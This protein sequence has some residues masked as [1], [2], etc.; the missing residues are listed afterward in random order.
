MPPRPF[1][2]KLFPSCWPIIF[3]ICMKEAVLASDVI[4]ERGYR[5]LLGKVDLEKSGFLLLASSELPV[6]SFHSGLWMVTRQDSS[7]VRTI[8]GRAAATK[9]SSTRSPAGSSNP[10]R[11]PAALPEGVGRSQRLR[12]GLPKAPR[13]PMPWLL[14]GPALSQ[15]PGSGDSKARTSSA[16]LPS[17]PTGTISPSRDRT[18]YLAFDSDIV[19][20]EPVRK[21]LEHLGEHLKRKGATVHVIHLPQEGQRRRY[22]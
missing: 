15:S 9:R 20:K 10:S 8:P 21:A 14:K 7:T 6:F 1:F 11:L 4:K 19:T 12:C 13:R 3:A 18:V 17:S 16:A 5:S 22:R 2:P